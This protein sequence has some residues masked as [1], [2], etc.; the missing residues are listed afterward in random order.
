MRFSRVRGPKSLMKTATMPQVCLRGLGN[1]AALTTCRAVVRTKA[2]LSVLKSH[3]EKPWSHMRRQAF[4]SPA[5]TGALP[6]AH[7]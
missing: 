6:R 4:R 3:Q 5:V 7:V 1:M 2:R